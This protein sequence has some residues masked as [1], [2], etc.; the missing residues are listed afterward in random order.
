MIYR[1]N[2]LERISV[3]IKTGDKF[4]SYTVGQVLGDILEGALVGATKFQ[5]AMDF[6]GMLID[7]A[8]PYYGHWNPIFNIFYKLEMV[9]K[10]TYYYNVF[11]VFYTFVTYDNPF[12]VVHYLKYDYAI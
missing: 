11:M 2:L 12:Y 10:N 3:E 7:N 4:D 1:G 5:E 6:F 9:L 8:G